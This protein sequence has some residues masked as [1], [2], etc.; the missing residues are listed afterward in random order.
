G[1]SDLFL[2]RDLALQRAVDKKQQW[3]IGLQ[4]RLALAS[5]SGG[6]WTFLTNFR[7]LPTHLLPF[8]G[9]PAINQPQTLR[10]RPIGS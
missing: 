6:T 9:L 5:F 4:T 3:R 10:V 2:D 8:R 7:P 1:S